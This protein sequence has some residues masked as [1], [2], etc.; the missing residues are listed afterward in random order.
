[1]R[2]PVELGQYT[3][4]IFTQRCRSVDVDVSMGSKGDCFDKGLVS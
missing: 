3:S 2:G 1:L 4:L